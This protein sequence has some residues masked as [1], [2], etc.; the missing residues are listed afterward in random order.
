MNLG[1]RFLLIGALFSSLSTTA[2]AKPIKQ[3]VKTQT[4]T[5]VLRQT[6]SVVGDQV[7]YCQASRIVCVNKTWHTTLL[8]DASTQ[9]AYL[10]NDAKKVYMQT[11]FDQWP[12]V[13][14]ITQPSRRSRFS[15]CGWYGVSNE[16]LAGLCCTKC[17]LEN[18]TKRDTTGRAVWFS[19]A[20]PIDKSLSAL[21]CKNIGLP[22]HN[23]FPLRLNTLGYDRRP[24]QELDTVQ[25]TLS[26][27]VPDSMFKHN[28]TGFRRC[29]SPID[30]TDA[31][32]GLDEAMSALVPPAVTY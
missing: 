28:F 13:A 2:Q 21:I 18:A 17:I 11:A 32:E 29:D 30:I 14:G 20:Y 6:G 9:Q 3:H 5:L 10:F 27:D 12:G 8:L 31:R 23:G 25:A 15:N 7:V 16:N 22:Q 26:R 4:P 1:I 24:H 19:E